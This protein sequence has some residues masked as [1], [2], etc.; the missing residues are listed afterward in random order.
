MRGEM[1]EEE[2]LAEQWNFRR[3]Y[4]AL[5]CNVCETHS[6]AEAIHRHSNGDISTEQR[7]D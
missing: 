4:G 6:L 1:L 5:L 7:C 2:D 3:H